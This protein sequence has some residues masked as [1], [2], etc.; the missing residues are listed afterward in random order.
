MLEMP[1]FRIPNSSQIIKKKK[2]LNL[3]SRWG[4]DPC[5]K[6]CHI[7]WDEFGTINLFQWSMW[8]NTH[9]FDKFV[10][11]CMQFIQISQKALQEVWN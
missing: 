6:D 4:C 5:K 8:T 10:S 7:G 2:K 9:M 1:N 3:K 11:T